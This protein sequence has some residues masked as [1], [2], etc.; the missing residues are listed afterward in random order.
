MPKS[1]KPQTQEIKFRPKYDTK[2]TAKTTLID[3]LSKNTITPQKTLLAGLRHKTLCPK[4]SIFEPNP[5][6]TFLNLF[7][8]KR[9]SDMLVNTNKDP[10][11]KLEV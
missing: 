6:P 2:I 10:E 9:F 7:V 8:E 5:D 4:V 11:A 3:S 1:N